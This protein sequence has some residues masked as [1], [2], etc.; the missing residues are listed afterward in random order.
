M[1]LYAVLN[2]IGKVKAF[3]FFFNEF[4]HTDALL[5]VLESVRTDLIKYFFPAVSE[6]GMSQVVTESDSL[7]Q[8][9]VE[10][11]STGNSSCYLR[12]FKGM[13]EAGAVMVAHR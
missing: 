8:I 5:V 13:C 12:Y 7:S 3:A 11:H 6:R 10:S 4:C 1:A 9:L 2:C